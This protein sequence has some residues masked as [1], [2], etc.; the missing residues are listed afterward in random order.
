MN[1]FYFEHDNTEDSLMEEM[2]HPHYNQIIQKAFYRDCTDEFSPFGNDDGAETLWDLEDWYREMQ[3]EEDITQFLFN[4]ID[5]YGFTYQSEPLVDTLD[6]ETIQELAE[7]DPYFIDTMDQTII[8]TAFG[9]AKITGMICPK[10]RDLA[11]IA[12][13]RQLLIAYQNLENKVVDM[14]KLL[15]VVDGETTDLDEAGT[16]VHLDEIYT[17]RLRIMKSD[18]MKFA[19]EV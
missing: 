17:K 1:Q 9:Q 2:S 15:K 8:A 18:L 5:N 11:V 13:N 6:L 4:R 19:M 16:T 10:L 14:S 7:E 3:G 12:V